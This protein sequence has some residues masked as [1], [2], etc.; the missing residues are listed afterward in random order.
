MNKEFSDLLTPNKWLSDSVC[1]GLFTTKINFKFYSFQIINSYLTV[2]DLKDNILLNY[3]VINQIINNV[4]CTALQNFDIHD[5]KFIVGPHFID[6]R[7]YAVIVDL[8]KHQFLMIDPKGITDNL[9]QNSFKNW[10]EF[11]MRRIDKQIDDW[12]A[13]KI[14]HPSQMDSYNCAIF[15]INFIYFY[16]NT[17]Q[18]EFD[19]S[20]MTAW[21]Y[22][23]ADTIKSNCIKLN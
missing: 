2:A 7:W 11:Y 3:Y 14:K 4:D 1:F 16:V 12:Q 8:S 15:V 10:V 19:S 21:R 5:F 20:N 17:G 22:K 18:I 23:V 9:L 6:C 13:I